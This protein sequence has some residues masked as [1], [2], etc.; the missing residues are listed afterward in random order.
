MDINAFMLGGDT[1]DYK[2]LR[3]RYPEFSFDGY[4]IKNEDG[5]IKVI[6]FFTQSE[7]IQ[8][9][10]EWI[11]PFSFDEYIEN[12]NSEF[13][14]SLIFNLGL[15]ELVSYWKACCSPKI[16]VRCGYLSD[17]QQ[18]FWKKLYFNGLGEFFYRNNIDAQFDTFVNF[19]CLYDYD[20]TGLNV[21]VETKGNLIAVGGGKDSVVSLELLKDF[22]HS[23][24][25]ITPHG[26]NI[27]TT[28]VAGYTDEK[29]IAPKRVLDRKIVEL[30]NKGY[31]NGH[32]P[33]SA[34]IAFSSYLCAFLAKKKY[35]VLS[36]ESSANESYVDG[37]EV[38]HQYSKSIEFENDFRDYVEKLA[39][40]KGREKDLELYKNV[41]DL[42][43]EV[44][45]KYRR[46]YKGVSP[47]VDFYSGLVYKMLD[48]PPDL[49]TP[50]FTI[51][52]IA[53]WSAHR[54]EELVTGGK[55]IRPA[56][57]S[58]NVRNIYVP[59]NNR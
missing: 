52:R 45:A 57:K 42:A 3:E 6:Y 20:H 11:L 7:D 43:P 58:N 59:M 1:V 18:L 51:A 34:V 55:I 12:E 46:I 33:L 50:I 56:Y 2:E 13:L 53:G 41:K 26:A 47:N 14:D 30:N 15:S 49:F 36:N 8:F 4:E 28:R 16:I 31:L 5:K 29:I 10:P 35:V 25:I 40:E 54:I 48:I 27:D 24:Y 21:P 9:F 38:N 19:E 17:E 32:T 39:V 22:D 37:K 23:C 44:I